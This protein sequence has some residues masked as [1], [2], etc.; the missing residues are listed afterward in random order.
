MV[1]SAAFPF[2]TVYELHEHKI[3]FI[4]TLALFCLITRLITIHS[5]TFLLYLLFY[6]VVLYVYFPFNQSFGFTWGQ[7][8]LNEIILFFQNTAMN[9]SVFLPTV[10][11]LPFF[12]Y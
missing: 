4:G 7:A 8:Y 11:A 2:L 12:C 9:Q 3:I 5:L 10:I 6:A 1:A